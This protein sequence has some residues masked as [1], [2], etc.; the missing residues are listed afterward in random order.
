MIPLVRRHPEV[1]R[2]LHHG[3][4]LDPHHERALLLVLGLGLA[5]RSHGVSLVLGLPYASGY[6]RHHASWPRTL[7]T[8]P[9]Y[10]LVDLVRTLSLAAGSVRHATPVL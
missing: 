4:F 9:G 7:A 2:S 1:R 5:R 3:V 10:A 8:L 6:R